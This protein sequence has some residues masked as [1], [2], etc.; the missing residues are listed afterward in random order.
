MTA[1]IEYQLEPR[2]A[3]EEESD[4]FQTL[5]DSVD[6]AR[7]PEFEDWENKLLLKQSILYERLYLQGLKDG[8]Q[9]ANVFTNPSVLLN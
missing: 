3:F 1:Q 7:M 9:L 8:M 6:I 5:F 2:Q 4:A